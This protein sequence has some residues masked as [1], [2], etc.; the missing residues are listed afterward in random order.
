MQRTRMAEAQGTAQHRGAGKFHLAR[1]QHDRL[2]ERLVIEFVVLAD[3]D[4]EQ[5]GVARERH[6][7]IHFMVLIDR[8]RICP[9]QTAIRQSMT[10]P[11]I[12]LPA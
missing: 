1:L 3:E 6:G 4:A 10:E 11:M 2:V 7:Q 9:S 8:A 5:D 12:L